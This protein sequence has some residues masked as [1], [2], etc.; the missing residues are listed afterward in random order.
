MFINLVQEVVRDALDARQCEVFNLCALGLLNAA[1]ED[2]ETYSEDLGFAL[3]HAVTATQRAIQKNLRHVIVA[4]ALDL[5]GRLLKRQAAFQ[6]SAQYHLAAI[7]MARELGEFKVVVGNLINLGVCLQ[8]AKQLQPAR[9][10]FEDALDLVREHRIDDPNLV[11]IIFTNLCYCCYLLH[12]RRGKAYGLKGLRLAKQVQDPTLYA[13][14]LNHLALIALAQKKPERAIIMFERALDIMRTLYGK[15]DHRVGITMNNLSSAYLDRRIA[16]KESKQKALNLACSALSIA[17]RTLGK[18]HPDVARIMGDLAIFVANT[19]RF[20]SA[21]TLLTNAYELHAGLYGSDN[22]N[23]NALL[24]H[25][26]RLYLSAGNLD[27]AASLYEQVADIYETLGDFK[28]A[29]FY[30][31]HL[32]TLYGRMRQPMYAQR[33]KRRA[34]MLQ[35][36]GA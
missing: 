21:K 5:C 25:L 13:A 3:P 23:T 7:S 17:K 14:N 22:K 1:Y 8:D 28:S 12:D 20:K 2:V 16:P 36:R 10:R 4:R 31:D 9:K 33:A 19:G 26:A 32:A 35:L 30:F 18:T 11:L 29:L 15:K 24:S 6:T 27:E 34:Q